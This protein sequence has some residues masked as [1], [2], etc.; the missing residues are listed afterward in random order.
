MAKLL[1]SVK[2]LGEKITGEK[3]NGDT[4]FDA[5][6]DAGE[7]MTGKEIEGKELNDVIAETAKEYQGGGGT[8]VVDELPETGE[9]HIIYELRETSKASYGW[10]FS[11]IPTTNISSNYFLVFDT[12]EQMT[13]TINAIKIDDNTLDE[14]YYA[15]IRNTNQMYFFSIFFPEDGDAYWVFNEQQK[16]VDESGTDYA[17]QL[18]TMEDY[19]TFYILKEFVG[20]EGYIPDGGNTY[21]YLTLDNKEVYI[22]H[23]GFGYILS[24]IVHPNYVAAQIFVSMGATVIS[25]KLPNSVELEEDYY[26]LLRATGGENHSIICYNTSNNKYY[27]L[28]SDGVDYYWYNNHKD[29]EGCYFAQNV[30]EVP[31]QE[32]PHYEGELVWDELRVDKLPNYDEI[33]YEGIIN[34]KLGD[35][36]W[37]FQPQKEG[38]ITSTYWIYSNGIWTNT[39]D[40]GKPVEQEVIYGELLE[41]PTFDTDHKFISPYTN[42]QICNY[43]REGKPVILRYHWKYMRENEFMYVYI[44]GYVPAEMGEEYVNQNLYYDNFTCRKYNTTDSIQYNL[45]SDYFYYEQG[46]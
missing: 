23:E 46:E 12:Y 38:E 30:E 27:G 18:K 28:V 25:N 42:E 35:T 33:P 16:K 15:Y 26:K 2:A 45:A 21:S 5:V 34:N 44:N 20:N 9:E 14:D 24:D 4:L 11:G 40:I 1:D 36:P 43:I 22:G 32:P 37:I 29:R 17:F 39:E 6:K 13:S 10:M 31:G 7:K 19:Q 8:V 41:G 3:I